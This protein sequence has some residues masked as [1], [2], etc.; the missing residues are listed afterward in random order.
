MLVTVLRSHI[1]FL[2]IIFILVVP[3]SAEEITSGSASIETD[4]YKLISFNIL[5]NITLGISGSSTGNLSLIVLDKINYSNWLSQ[6]SYISILN[7]NISIGDFDNKIVFENI[8]NDTQ[9][10]ILFINTQ[11]RSVQL[12][13]LMEIISIQ[14]KKASFPLFFLIPILLI[15][16][17]RF[18][19]Y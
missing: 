4:T 8:F 5:G 16:L 14:D 19:K 18:K 6:A 15:P 2:F 3:T 12:E 13:Y 1:T 17:L 11:S 9:I 10:H 7:A